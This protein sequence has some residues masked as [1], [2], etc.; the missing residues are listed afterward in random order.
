[1]MSNMRM[2]RHR[3]DF[4]NQSPSASYVS[5][6]TPSASSIT[7]N[8][9][10]LGSNADDIDSVISSNDNNT[11]KYISTPKKPEY[12]SDKIWKQNKNLYNKRKRTTTPTNNSI[13]NDNLSDLKTMQMDLESNG[14]PT[15]V[16]SHKTTPMSSIYSPDNQYGNTL[17]QYK[18]IV[19]LNYVTDMDTQSINNIELTPK[20]ARPSPITTQLP[21]IQ[22]IL[23]N[24]E[25]NNNNTNNNNNINNNYNNN[26]SIK[27]TN[28]K[29]NIKRNKYYKTTKPKKKKGKF[30]PFPDES[31]LSLDD[32]AFTLPGPSP[33]ASA[34]KQS[35][36]ISP[37]F[38][39]TRMRE[40]YNNRP[41]KKRINRKF[42]S[43]YHKY[44]R[45]AD[46]NNNKYNIN[47][48]G[49][50]YPG[51]YTTDST[52]TPKSVTNTNTNTTRTIT[53]NNRKSIVY[54]EMI[55]PQNEF[56]YIAID[57]YSPM[58]SNGGSSTEIPTGTDDD[59]KDEIAQLLRDDDD[60]NNDNETNNDYQSETKEMDNEFNDI[61]THDDVLITSDTNIDEFNDDNNDDNDD[62]DEI[63]DTNI[64]TH[65][66]I[67]NDINDIIVSKPND[68]DSDNNINDINDDIEHQFDD[69]YNIEIDYE[70]FKTQLQE[71]RLSQPTPNLC[72]IMF[73]TDAFGHER[74]STHN[75]INNNITKHNKSK[76]YHQNKKQRPPAI[77]TQHQH[78]P[79]STFSHPKK[80]KKSSKKR[81]KKFK[82]PTLVPTH[83]PEYTQFSADLPESIYKVK[84]KQPIQHKSLEYYLSKHEQKQ[85]L[86]H[87]KN[88]YKKYKNK[89][90]SI[91]SYESETNSNN[92]H[93][94][95]RTTKYSH[96]TF[97]TDKTLTVPKFNENHGSKSLPH[98][99][100][101]I[102]SNNSDI[103]ATKKYHHDYNISVPSSLKP[104]L[105]RVSNSVE[106]NRKDVVQMD[107]SFLDINMYSNSSNKTCFV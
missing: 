67:T 44:Q 11:I 93:T 45:I 91:S 102:N 61:N 64:M 36:L 58:I 68:D 96:Y 34:S 2:L 86:K 98:R 107:L 63:T 97:E 10:Y 56:K 66:S 9:R 92:T 42:R 65:I 13:N 76:S 53:N 29:H 20:S 5:S 103:F 31:S 28:I 62:D 57:Q 99:K 69:E 84:P 72:D 51:H 90:P 71:R 8:S 1:M 43:K 55:K 78:I 16:S 85:I 17:I 46:K 49:T 15:F 95:S 94:R 79:T 41:I 82:A 7:Y 101:S 104:K 12:M 81:S 88:K 83:Q 32:G 100:I 23:S 105:K 70:K 33:S 54:N 3:I 50:P 24:H 48:L 35:K 37:N 47:N 18:P 77:I 87:N 30:S 40:T 89:Y 60:M 21:P 106:F 26:N 22:I 52:I 19:P 74:S 14:S 75:Y 4:P 73:D 39:M 80:N 59:I 38:R 6:D 27:Y 25:M